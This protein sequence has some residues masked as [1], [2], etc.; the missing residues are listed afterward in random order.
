MRQVSQIEIAKIR[1]N[2]DN[3]RATVNT[4]EPGFIELKN[5]IEGMG[6]KVPIMVR[7][8]GGEGFDLLAGARRL[9]ASKEL[10]LKEIPAIIHEGLTD[11]EAFDVTFAENYN[12]KDLSLL[13]QVKAVEILMAKYQ[14]D[15]AAVA[16][17]LGWDK[18]TVLCRLRISKMS[19]KMLKKL[20]DGALSDFAPAHL[21]LVARL[22]VKAQEQVAGQLYILDDDITVVALKKKLADMFEH[23]LAAAPWLQVDKGVNGKSGLIKV[24]ADCGRCEKRT[25]HKNTLALFADEADT[26]KTARCL[27][28]DCWRKNQA[29]AILALRDEAVKTNGDI[30]TVHVCGDGSTY[31]EDQEAKKAGHQVLYNLETK[32]KAFPGSK[33]VFLVNGEHAG[34]VRYFKPEKRG[35]GGGG[36]VGRPT[37]GPKTLKERREGLESKRWYCVLETL[38]EQIQALK[39]DQVALTLPEVAV[40]AAVFG[41][42]E[43]E[44]YG[45]NLKPWKTYVGNKGSL[46]TAFN[47]FAAVRPV[48]I[49]RLSPGCGVTQVQKEYV[50]EA[51]TVGKL[52]ALDVDAM[53]ADA[54]KENPEPKSWAG[55]KAD[56]TPKE[57]KKE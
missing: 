46:S 43:N 48:L 49:S 21:D 8:D 11:A 7:S 40:L 28:A 20:A 44:R 41:T 24:P 9:A 14:G 17:K 1:V 47:L 56:G 5:N 45:G 23:A 2:K 18:K 39:A 25:D 32:T 53:H 33:P 35:E 10:G 15:T 26:C 19:P 13:E 27:D 16:S 6:V 12:R 54:V 31:Q 57:A 50:E 42:G 30:A 29:A 38:K 55:L 22:P 4:K 34:T 36:S 37:E 52:L 3:P 51:R